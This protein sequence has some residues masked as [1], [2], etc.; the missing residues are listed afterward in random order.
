LREF[1]NF[2][3]ICDMRNGCGVDQIILEHT[4]VEKVNLAMA[5]AT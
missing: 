4:A 1:E 2:D 5:L 3:S